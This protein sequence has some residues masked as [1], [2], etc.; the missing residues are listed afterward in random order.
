LSR[1]QAE[2]ITPFLGL[3]EEQAHYFILMV[4]S[5]RAGSETLR[6]YYKRQMAAT[7][8]NRKVLKN[9]MHFQKILSVED[10][11]L[12]YSSW[13]YGAFHVAVSLPGCDTERG[14]SHYFDVPLKKVNEIVSF[15]IQTG[16]VVRHDSKLSVGPH[17]VFL[18]SDSP[19]VSKLHS[20]WRIEAMKSLDRYTE[21]DLHYSSV[22]TASRQ[23]VAVIREI[24]VKSIEEIRRVVRSSPHEACFVYDLDLFELGN[25][26]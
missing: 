2:K 26:F 23:D 14:L 21:N 25:S 20:N 1:E 17:Q 15:L 24:M 3:G 13:H 18:G 10:Q 22:V 16:L 8:E 11:A 12:F 9:R 6:R 5:A 7:K 19:L 4:S